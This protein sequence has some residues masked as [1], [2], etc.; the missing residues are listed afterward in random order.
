[1]KNSVKTPKPL[2]RLTVIIIPTIIIAALTLLILNH[3]GVFLSVEDQAIGKWSR[4]RQGTYS[5]ETYLETYRFYSDGTGFKSY[6]SPDGYMAKKRFTW[7]VTPTKTLVI[8][9]HIKYA[10]NSNYLKYYN[11]TAKTTK[12]YWY[13]SKNHL[14]IGQNTSINSE[15]YRR[16]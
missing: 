13:V 15:V 10:W 14:Y 5:K 6:T 11:E 3:Y 2:I 12:K 1:M 4:T 7:S 9:G 8:N 16:K